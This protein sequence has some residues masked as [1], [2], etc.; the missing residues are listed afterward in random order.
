MRNRQM[1]Y[2]A[3]LEDKRVHSLNHAPIDLHLHFRDDHGMRPQ[4]HHPLLPRRRRA[5]ERTRQELM[6]QIGGGDVRKRLPVL[7]V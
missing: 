7:G 3:Y 2:A 1:K 4:R 6:L 5:R